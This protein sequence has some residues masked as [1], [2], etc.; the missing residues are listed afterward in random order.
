MTHK[1]LEV[2]KL[3]GGLAENDRQKLRTFFEELNKKIEIA[4]FQKREMVEDFYKL[5]EMYLDEGKSVQEIID[6][7]N[8]NHLGDFYLARKGEWIMLDNA[9]II[10][11]LGMRHGRMPMFRLA[12]T[13]KEEV[14]PRV[15][16]VALYF[17]IKRFPTF[18]SV[19]KRGFFWH[20]LETVNHAIK[21]EEEKDA[22]CKPIS[23]L[24]RSSRSYRVLY[25]KNRISLEVFH[26][27]TDGSGAF[28]F[29]KSL[30]AEYFRLLGR[31]ISKT[32][33]VFDI[34]EAPKDEE[35]F[36]AF[37]MAKGESSM[38]SFL[39]ASSLQ[40]DG[41]ISLKNPTNIYH[42]EMDSKELINKAKSNGVT[43]TAYIL[44]LMFMASK[45]AMSNKSGDMNIQVPVN[46]R[47]YNY[48]K[49]LRNYSMYFSVTRRM[50]KEVSKEELMEDI[51]KQMKIK[52]S[53]EEMTKMMGI[54]NRLITSLRYVPL[55][56][57]QPVAQMVYGY[58]GNS[59]I[60]NVLSNLGVIEVPKEMEEYIESFDAMFLPEAPNK[61]TSTLVS[62]KGRTRFTIVKNVIDDRYENK[63][64]E[65]LKEEGLDPKVYGSIT[66]ES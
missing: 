31:N 24:L 25:Y 1:D 42:F 51:S 27:I 37:K 44:A 22:P 34:E 21:V 60:G 53:E 11:P 64:Y 50:D 20:Y 35:R 39:G 49:T 26:V 38:N 13:L 62:F 54:T 56:I 4:P 46:M 12:A 5:V 29:L 8:V 32:N 3:C 15:L 33:G 59:I 45:E 19:V 10:Y 57:K 16:Q 43:V 48:P 2:E 52:G 18:A 63:L 6:L 7:L 9:A 41:K 65:L 17:T 47:K 28:I 58:L 14:D 23:L 66:Y 30:L 40:L 36:N 55:I 61:A